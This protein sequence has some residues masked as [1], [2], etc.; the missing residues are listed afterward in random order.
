[1][2]SGFGAVDHRVGGGGN[3]GAGPAYDPKP[4]LPA[5]YDRVLSIIIRVPPTPRLALHMSAVVPR[6]IRR[7]NRNYG[8]KAKPL[9]AWTARPRRDY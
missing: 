9:S 4:G 2:P 1:M 6:R 3:A 7:L 8:G 5:S